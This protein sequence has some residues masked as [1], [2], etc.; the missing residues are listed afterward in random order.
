MAITTFSAISNDAPNVFI[1]NETLKV[2]NRN[3][4]L[5]QYGKKVPL[6]QRNGKTIRVI[7]RTRLA[8]PHTPL[9]EGTTPDSLAFNYN[10]VDIPVSQ[11]GIVVAMS[12]V[13][14]VT[15]KHPILNMAIEDKAMAM[16]EMFERETAEEL[17]SGTRVIFA[18][19]AN[20]NSR[21]DLAG[22]DLITS[23][24]IVAAKVGLRARGVPGINGRRYAGVLSPQQVGDI[25]LSDEKFT[26]AAEQS[27]VAALQFGMVGTWH[28]VD[29]TEGNFLPILKGVAAPDTNTETAEKA[30]HNMS[31]TGGAIDNSLI[32]IVARDANSDYERKV[33]QTLTVADADASFTLTLPTSTNYVYDVYMTD[34]SGANEKLVKSR[35]AAST[36]I[37]VNAALYSAGTLAASPVAPASGVEVFIGWVF[38][39]DAFARVDLDGMSLQSFITPNAASD[40]DPLAQRR[41]VGSKAM[42]KVAILDNDRFVRLETGSSYPAELPA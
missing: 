35:Q 1:A 38:G 19:R 28:D 5:G 2:L 32:K 15:T 7:K 40:S 3:L 36:A 31:S 10:E 8:V 29:I 41:K 9:T 16:A 24:E 22:T 4:I 34:T 21:D 42:W 6:P 11:W 25:T 27:N 17:M 12:D 37:T 30:K 18:D 14:Q 20:N 13:A 39:K 26:T 23:S 33:S